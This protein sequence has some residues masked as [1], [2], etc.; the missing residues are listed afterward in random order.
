MR[1]VFH[2][3]AHSTDEDRIARVLRRNAAQLDRAGVVVP[4]PARFAN[5]LR[6]TLVSL[7]GKPASA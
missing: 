7:R 2:I 6:D 5:V 1:V 3:G 4:W